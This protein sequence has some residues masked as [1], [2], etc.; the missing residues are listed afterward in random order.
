M[1]IILLR[2]VYPLQYPVVGF[3][4]GLG[5]FVQI[6]AEVWGDA[7]LQRVQLAEDPSEPVQQSENLRPASNNMTL[8]HSIGSFRQR[9]YHQILIVRPPSPHR[10]A[11][12]RVYCTANV[13]GDV[14]FL[15]AFIM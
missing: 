6:V 9:L 15:S 3:V 12:G 5:Q 10:R 4:Q 7:M 1:R 8:S 11:R 2:L 14:R 13:L